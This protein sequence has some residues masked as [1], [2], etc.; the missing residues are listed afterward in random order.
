MD[1]QLPPPMVLYR[2]ATAH[3]LSQA[4]Y[5][6]AKLGIADL[7]ADGPQTHETLAQD[8]A[9]TRRRSAACSGCSP[10]PACS[11][12]TPTGASS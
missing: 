7:L 9:R 8:Q 1:T 10:A 3:Y 12:R 2:L 11:P 5:V 6:A 4:L